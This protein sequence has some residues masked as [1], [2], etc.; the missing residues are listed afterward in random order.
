V[1]EREWLTSTDPP[2]MLFFLR[3]SGQLIRRKARLFAVACC[4]RVWRLL[5]DPRSRRAVEAAELFAD[6]R[7]RGTALA[8]AYAAGRQA[9]LSLIP[10]QQ[11][12]GWEALAAMAAY[13][14][15]SRKV[16]EAM[17][18]TPGG[19]VQAVVSRRYPGPADPGPGGRR[20]RRQEYKA[21][22]ALLRDLFG[23]LPFRAVAVAPS[24]LRWHGGTVRK[25]ALAAYREQSLPAGTLDNARLAVLADAIE[26]AGCTDEELLGHLRGPGAH[27]RG[28]F[29]LDLLLGRK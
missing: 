26:D 17:L 27:V 10:H 13:G 12:A 28:C 5:A 9:F 8:A 19:A 11:P 29:A 6:R 3:D 25:L 16:A 24:L 22:A 20:L 15:A 23:P 2:A 7:V 21:Q 4:R 14:A 1:D 18:Q